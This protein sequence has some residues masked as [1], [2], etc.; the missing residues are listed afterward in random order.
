MGRSGGAL[1]MLSGWDYATKTVQ[2]SSFTATKLITFTGN[3]AVSQ[4][5]L[6]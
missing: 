4:G 6:N 2:G 1:M 5:E 3:A